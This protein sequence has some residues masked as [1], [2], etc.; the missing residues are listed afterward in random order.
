MLQINI[1][2]K[3]SIKIQNIEGIS[4]QRGNLLIP[5][6]VSTCLDQAIHPLADFLALRS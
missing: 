5:D 4:R 3:S 1:A 2:L 6:V